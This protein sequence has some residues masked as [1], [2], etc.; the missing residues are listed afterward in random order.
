MWVD[1]FAG[2]SL[3]VVLG[4]TAAGALQQA[5]QLGDG[6]LIDQDVLSCGPTPRRTDLREWQRV[7]TD[8]WTNLVPGL[9]EQHQ[10]SPRNF[11][12]HVEDLRG[13][14]RLILWTATGVSEQLFVASV[15]NLVAS[16]SLPFERVAVVQFENLGGRRSRVMGVGELDEESLRN[17]PEPKSLTQQA[18]AEYLAAWD[19]L[20]SPDPRYMET[21]AN[22]HPTAS[23]WLK[24]AMRLMLRR[25]PDRRSGL[26]H[27]DFRLLENA[28]RNGPNAAGIVGHTMTE[29]WD[30][31]DLV[32]D[33]YL[34][35]RLLRLGAE[36]LPKP[37]LTVTGNQREMRSVQVTLTPFGIDVLEG[38]ASNLS[39]NPIEEWAAGVQLSSRAK[40]VWM[41]EGDRLFHE[42]VS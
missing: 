10:V 12:Q 28:H 7:R 5:Y 20:T 3:H 1:A 37:L 21:F 33:W 35:G 4:D 41:R 8:Y 14:Q 2:P 38:R 17:H 15:C 16:M 40:H 39:A 18:A 42:P 32:G 9:I 34:Y 31:G 23:T 27:W 36:H 13:A 24:N 6:L 29:N 26:S 30:D 19:A 25:F 22:D 11:L